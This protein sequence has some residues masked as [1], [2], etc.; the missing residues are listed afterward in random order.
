[1]SARVCKKDQIRLVMEC[2]Q[3]GLSDYQWCEQ[4]GMGII[5]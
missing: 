2:R 1:M 5:K 3:S 4:N